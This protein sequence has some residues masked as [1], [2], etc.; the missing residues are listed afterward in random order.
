MAELK[1]KWHKYTTPAG[2]A[3]PHPFL[4][5]HVGCYLVALGVANSEI[6]GD[7][8]KIDPNFKKLSP[9]G[10]RYFAHGWK[11]HVSDG[12]GNKTAQESYIII[13]EAVKLAESGEWFA[14]RDSIAARRMMYLANDMAVGTYS[15][16]FTDENLAKMVALVSNPDND[17]KLKGWAAQTKVAKATADREY[18]EA[19]ADI[20]DDDDEEPDFS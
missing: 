7:L 1:I 10:K 5:G 4:S 9:H 12:T 18:A 14:K 3:L 16:E 15:L 17:A 2:S 11:Q 20:D 19:M 6:L 13:R 8:N